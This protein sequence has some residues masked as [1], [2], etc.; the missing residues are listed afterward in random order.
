[1]SMDQERAE[2]HPAPAVSGPRP[3]V[4]PV[5]IQPAFRVV[6]GQCGQCGPLGGDLHDEAA[7][8]LAG[9]QDR[10]RA[11]LAGQ[12]DDPRTPGDD[13]TVRA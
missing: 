4:P 6:C 11:P 3:D 1:M 7:R 13:V 5:T 12:Y 10:I 8:A 2:K 9:R